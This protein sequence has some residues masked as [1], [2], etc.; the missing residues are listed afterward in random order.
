MIRTVSNKYIL[1]PVLMSMSCQRFCRNQRRTGVKI[2]VLLVETIELLNI[3]EFK[4]GTCFIIF[5]EFH[6]PT[7]RSHFPNSGAEV[8]LINKIVE[9]LPNH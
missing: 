6:S 4:F 1:T 3:H 9:L 7:L 2:L 8:V 5:S